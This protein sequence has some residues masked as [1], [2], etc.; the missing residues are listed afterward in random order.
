MASNLAV[1][2]DKHDKQ[3]AVIQRLIL[4]GMKM[5]NKNSADIQALIK[6]QRETDRI[7]KNLMLSLGRQ[8]RTNGHGKPPK[9]LA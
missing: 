4:T 5:I 6:A 8:E 7:L 3:I 2:V 1:R 9:G